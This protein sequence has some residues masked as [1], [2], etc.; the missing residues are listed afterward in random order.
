MEPIQWSKKFSVGVKVLDQ[1][2]QHLIKL[3]NLLI[4]VDNHYHDP[5]VPHTRGDEPSSAYISAC[6]TIMFPP[7]LGMNRI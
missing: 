3:L 1:Q 4:D 7:R 2:H 5:N 6:S